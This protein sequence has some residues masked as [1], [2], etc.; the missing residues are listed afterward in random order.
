MCLRISKLGHT[1]PVNQVF[2]NGFSKEIKPDGR[3]Q[4]KEKPPRGNPG[5]EPKR[6]VEE[7][8]IPRTLCSSKQLLRVL[9]GQDPVRQAVLI[10]GQRQFRSGVSG[11]L[12]HPYWAHSK[13]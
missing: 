11:D 2:S 12:S 7:D 10:A 6:A 4:T 3:H 8:A 13:Q 5:G 1:C 9:L